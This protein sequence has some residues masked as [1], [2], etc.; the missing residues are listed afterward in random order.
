[1]PTSTLEV[2]QEHF[3]QPSISSHKIKLH[4]IHDYS[5]QVIIPRKKRGHGLF[6]KNTCSRKQDEKKI[7]HMNIQEFKKKERKRL[8]MSK[9]KGIKERDGP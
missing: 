4:D 8:P 2:A 7:G 9:E 1:L 5:L 6:K 3:T